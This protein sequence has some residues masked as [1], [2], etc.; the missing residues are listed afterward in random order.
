MSVVQRGAVYFS[1]E[2]DFDRAGQGKLVTF[3]AVLPQLLIMASPT[4]PRVKS[5]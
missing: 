2:Y 3:G 1:V 4:T 5:A